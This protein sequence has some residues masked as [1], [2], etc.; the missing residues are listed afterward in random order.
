MACTVL[1][2]GSPGVWPLEWSPCMPS[3]G[4]RAAAA[5]E[6][7]ARTVVW[8]VAGR[9]LEHATRCRF[10]M[11]CGV[12]ARLAQTFSLNLTRNEKTTRAAKD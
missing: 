5:A 6:A 8:L 9:F 4:A 10:A 11:L 1:Q 2:Y 7:E 3:K 12:F